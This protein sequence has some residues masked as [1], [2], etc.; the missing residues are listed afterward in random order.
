VNVRLF[1]DTFNDTRDSVVV[2]APCY[3]PEGRGF[4]TQ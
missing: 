3:Q 1:N 4:D 2:K